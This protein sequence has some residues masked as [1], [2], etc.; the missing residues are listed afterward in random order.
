MNNYLKDSGLDETLKEHIQ[1]L[2]KEQPCSFDAQTLKDISPI[3]SLN[4]LKAA[5]VAKQDS[6][7]ERFASEKR[8]RLKE[9]H[10]HQ[11][12]GDVKLHEGF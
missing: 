4:D 1:N 7:K 3:Y 6:F 10:D 9:L 5:I 8:L 11:L 2:L 12:K